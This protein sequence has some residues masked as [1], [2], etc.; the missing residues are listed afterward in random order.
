VTATTKIARS[1]IMT[2]V[3]VTGGAGRAGRPVVQRLHDAGRE[4]RV[5]SHTR[6][7]AIDGVDYVRGDLVTGEGIDRAV[8]GAGIII[9]CAGTTSFRRDQAMT[10]NL[11][12]AARRLP[13]PPHLV[14]ISVVGAD[15]VP[16][17]RG[18]GRLMFGYFESMVATERAVERSGLPWSTLRAAQFF[19]AVALIAQAMARLPLIPVPSGIRFQ[20]VDAGEVADR[21]IEL[22]FG[23]PAGLAPDFAGPTAYPMGDLLRGYLTAVGRQRPLM[24]VHLP[25]KIARALRDGANLPRPAGPAANATLGRRT[26]EEFL[27]EQKA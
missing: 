20:P 22:A 15:R 13:T 24:P 2:L 19:D 9:H 23:P 5:L 10:A 11:I 1:D 17:G 7:P 25:G 16:V 27:A 18:L 14:K 21:L 8:G 3:L 6:K 4:L 26:W 12:Q